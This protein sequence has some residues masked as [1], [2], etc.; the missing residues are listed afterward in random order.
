[1]PTDSI[2]ATQSNFNFAQADFNF[3]QAGVDLDQSTSNAQNFQVG[4]DDG[5]EIEVGTAPF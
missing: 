2:N 3:G 1:M 5:F 4:N